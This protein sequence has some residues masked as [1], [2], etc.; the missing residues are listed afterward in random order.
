M[1]TLS[2]CYDTFS[3]E[4][5]PKEVAFR[6]GVLKVVSLVLFSLSTD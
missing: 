5:V 3:T 2:M 1:T 6:F 4:D